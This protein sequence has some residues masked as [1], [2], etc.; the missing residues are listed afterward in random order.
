MMREEWR[1]WLDEAGWDLETA[2]ILYQNGRY[3]ASCF[4]AHQAGEKAVKAL[5][6]SINEAG[7]G[8][9]IRILLERYMEKSGDQSAEKLFGDA[10]E[11]DRHYIPSRYPNAHPS[12]TAYEAY[13]QDTSRKAIECASRILKYASGRLLRDGLGEA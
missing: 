2:K 1:R 7:W 9:S 5:L 6:Y 4:Y 3:N 8:H 13:D 12:G 11:L 10:R